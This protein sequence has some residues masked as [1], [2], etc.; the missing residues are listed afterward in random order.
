MIDELVISIPMLLLIQDQEIVIYNLHKFWEIA[1][2][3]SEIIWKRQNLRTCGK[4][5]LCSTFYESFGWQP[6]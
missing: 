1:Q 5:M 6:G 3:D 4:M 2:N